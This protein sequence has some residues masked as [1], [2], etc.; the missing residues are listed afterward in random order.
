MTDPKELVK[1]LREH[2]IDQTKSIAHIVDD[3]HLDT[4]W[5]EAAALIEAQSK[6]PLSREEM[7]RMLIK[8]IQRDPCGDVSNWPK[9]A[10]A[11]GE[12][13]QR[14]FMGGE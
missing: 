2:A 7:E 8:Q 13:I 6:P 11:F 1:R 4:L 5:W 9:A 12:A 14:H 3:P 10:L